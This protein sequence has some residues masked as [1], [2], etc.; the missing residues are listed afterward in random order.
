M[1]KVY[2]GFV[3]HGLITGWLGWRGMY[4][5][6]CTVGALWCVGT[7]GMFTYACARAGAVGRCVVGA[8]V[9]GFGLA[10]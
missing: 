4:T 3:Y 9:A 5:Y 1:R 8:E 10:I 2:A 6:A 7:G